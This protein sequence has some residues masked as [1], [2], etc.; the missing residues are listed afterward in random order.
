MHLDLYKAKKEWGFV[1]QIWKDK[2]TG[3]TANAMFYVHSFLVA[4]LSTEKNNL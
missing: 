2:F 4:F 1:G 3:N